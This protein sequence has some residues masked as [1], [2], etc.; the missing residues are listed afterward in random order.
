MILRFALS[1]DSHRTYSYTLVFE[2]AVLVIGEL[3]YFLLS[4]IR[5]FMVIVDRLYLRGKDFLKSF[6]SLVVLTF[7]SPVPSSA[8]SEALRDSIVLHFS[9]IS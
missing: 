1:A 8:D 3:R 6:R 7:V 2:I 5:S 9:N 4:S